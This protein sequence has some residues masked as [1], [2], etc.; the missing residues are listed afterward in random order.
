MTQVAAWTGILMLGAPLLVQAVEGFPTFQWPSE[1][2][3]M[4]HGSPSGSACPALQGIYQSVG[5][6]WKS[7]CAEKTCSQLEPSK[8]EE[9]FAVQVHP[10]TKP[11]A[12][13]STFR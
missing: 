11:Y 8:S 5:G 12:D 13:H 10:R 7:R 6:S 2:P 9:L 3:E 4:R 1:L